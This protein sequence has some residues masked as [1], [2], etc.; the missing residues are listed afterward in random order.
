MQVTYTQVKFNLLIIARL[1][2]HWLGHIT[3]RTE[4]QWG[5]NLSVGLSTKWRED[6]IKVAGTRCMRIT[7]DR[8]VYLT[9]GEAYVQIVQHWTSFDCYDDD[10][11][12]A[13]CIIIIPAYIYTSHCRAQLRPP[14]RRKALGHADPV[15]NE[16]DIYRERNLTYN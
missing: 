13:E 15:R 2:C 11:V 7:Q 4:G 5:E 8:S 16:R 6:Q 12:S 3:R 10:I 14:L 1:G 9:V